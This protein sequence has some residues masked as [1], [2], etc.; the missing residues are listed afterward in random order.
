MDVYHKIVD[1]QAKLSVIGL[2]YVGMPLA[3]AFAKKVG[4]IG[5]DISEK[6][7]SGYL[8]GEDPTNEVGSE[9][10]IGSGIHFTCDETI[11]CNG[12]SEKMLGFHLAAQVF[13]GLFI[14]ELLLG[15]VV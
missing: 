13:I 5:Y 1:G 6:V 8:K 12:F 14:K 2:G 3:I 9:G 7:I 11:D 4:V 10:I 15:V